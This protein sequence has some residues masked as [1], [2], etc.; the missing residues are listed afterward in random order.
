[1]NNN[2][3]DSESRHRV[4]LEELLKEI[5]TTDIN[6]PIRDHESITENN[7]GMYILAKIETLKAQKKC[8]EEQLGKAE[9]ALTIHKAMEEDRILSCLESEAEKL[10]LTFDEFVEAVNRFNTSQTAI[11]VENKSERGKFKTYYPAEVKEAAIEAMFSG[12]SLQDIEK[13]LNIPYN[14]LS[15]W[16]V[17]AGLAKK[18][19]QLVSV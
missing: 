15:Q 7:R 3:H 16:K 1:M 13:D 14:T 2:Q 9:I 11:P 17:K 8:I 6:S 12:K 19:S 4:N 5:E 18:R 10:G